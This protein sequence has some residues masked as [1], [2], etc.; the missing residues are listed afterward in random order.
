VENRCIDFIF[1]NPGNLS[2]EISAQVGATGNTSI[3][4]MA[5]SQPSATSIVPLAIVDKT[6]ISLTVVGVGFYLPRD[7][8]RIKIGNQLLTGSVIDDRTLIVVYQPSQGQG[9][10]HVALETNGAQ[11]GGLFLLRILSFGVNNTPSLR[12]SY[13]RR[14]AGT[15][16]R[17]ALNTGAARDAGANIFCKIGSGDATAAF[18]FLDVVSC[19]FFSVPSDFLFPVPPI[20]SIYFFLKS[21]FP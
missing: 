3:S 9:D 16:I 12:P 6:A 11:L 1:P 15:Q 17:V 10:Q 2:V 8:L 5:V 20:R 4:I 19:S 21:Y 18:V 7:L 14:I 13:G